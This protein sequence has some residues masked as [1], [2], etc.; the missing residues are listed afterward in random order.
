M[1]VN[2]TAPSGLPPANALQGAEF[3][4]ITQ[5][6][7]SRSATPAQMLVYFLTNINSGEIPENGNLYFTNGRADARV[8]LHANRTDNPHAVT[9]AQVGLGNV[10]NIL[11]NLSAT[12]DPTITNDSSQGYSVGSIWINTST[13]KALICASSTV[14]NASWTTLST[15]GLTKADIGLGNVENIAISTWVGS[16]NITTVGSAAVTSHVGEINHDALLNYVSAKH[17]DHSSVHIN[18][19]TGLSGGGDITTDRTISFNLSALTAIGAVNIDAANDPMVI[20]DVSAGT[21]KSLTVSDILSQG[22]Q[23]VVPKRNSVLNCSSDSNNYPNYLSGL[24][25]GFSVLAT[26]GVPLVLSFANGFNAQGS[27]D[28]VFYGNSNRNVPIVPGVTNYLSIKSNTGFTSYND[29]EDASIKPVYD[30]KFDIKNASLL[31]FEG[32]A[33]DDYANGWTTGTAG[34]TTIIDSSQFKFGTQSLKRPAAATDWGLSGTFNPPAPEWSVEFWL[35]MPS[36]ASA[37]LFS[38]VNAA[39]S[40]NGINV[41]MSS[42]GV[43]SATLTSDGTTAITSTIGSAGTAVVG[44]AVWNHIRINFNG[45]SYTVF[46]GGKVAWCLVTTTRVWTGAILWR[47]LNSTVDMWMDELRIHNGF[48]RAGTGVVP[49]TGYA[50]DAVWY[51]TINAICYQGGPGAWNVVPRSYYGEVKANYWNSL[52]HFD[53]AVTTDTFGQNWVNNGSATISSTTSKFGGNALFLGTSLNKY[54]SIKDPLLNSWTG[55]FD[56]D[57]W[58]NSTT[59]TG[60]QTIFD[61]TNAGGFGL[62]VQINSSGN[63]VLLGSS[64]GTTNAALTQT[65]T[66]GGGLPCVSNTWYQL[67]IRNDGTNIKFY[68]NGTTVY[69]YSGAALTIPDTMFIGCSRAA[70]DGLQG[71]IDELKVRAGYSEKTGDFTSPSS[72]YSDSNNFTVTSSITHYNQLSQYDDIVFTPLTGKTGATTQFFHNIGSNK[73]KYSYYLQNITPELGFQAGE[74]TNYLGAGAPEFTTDTHNR[75]SVTLPSTVNVVAKSNATVTAITAAN[76]ALGVKVERD[77]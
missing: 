25:Q 71:Y 46:V 7:Q 34:A 22:S 11:S 42:G 60:T 8:N 9:K 67:A 45:E 65:I 6:G 44:A 54:L 74:K 3:M 72:A 27:I 50:V 14:G 31:H 35:Y 21:H 75:S 2:D 68:I 77:F 39:G 16:S 47:F 43:I 1:A 12:T 69:T 19:G 52:L 20:F 29:S 32:S 48:C 17:V 62:K 38:I 59:I 56:L 63:L 41:A 26:L 40:S 76:W 73:L 5:T 23:L 10:Q 66:T 58:F 33:A 30:R 51:D 64:N 13:G 55:L 70:N 57:F 49:S 15:S 37:N 24:T 4:P 36:L 61:W 28:K 53:S 18:T